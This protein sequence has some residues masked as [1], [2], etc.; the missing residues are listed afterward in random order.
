MLFL[1]VFI[2][3][4]AA[5]GPGFVEVPDR[6]RAADHGGAGPR[7]EAEP[8]SAAGDPDGPVVDDTTADA[9]AGDVGGA[10]GV[11]DPAAAGDPNGAVGPGDPGTDVE[12]GA[13]CAAAD[14]A[15]HASA[16]AAT[17]C[18]AP[19]LGSAC[20]YSVSGSCRAP[21]TGGS[22][23]C[24]PNPPAPT[25]ASIGACSGKSVDAACSFVSGTST[26]SGTCAAPPPSAPPGAPLACAP[27][28]TD[29]PTPPPEAVTACNGNANG[30][31]CSYSVDGTCRLAAGD[32]AACL[33][34]CPR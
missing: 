7:A 20:Q 6:S 32:T 29:N 16:E 30:G 34:A 10:A 14:L 19:A 21:S 3:V 18:V 22:L 27:A 25:P 15:I 4:T 13:A 24:G 8:S 31:S 1:F 26:L 28:S 11:G 23:A 2:G 17:A 12:P 33:S 9:S 5:C